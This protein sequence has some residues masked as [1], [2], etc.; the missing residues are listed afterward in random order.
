MEGKVL[1]ANNFHAQ[2][3][4]TGTY[5][6]DIPELDHYSWT[7]GK[8]IRRQARTATMEIRYQVLSSCLPLGYPKAEPSIPLCLVE[9][10]ETTEQLPE[11]ENQLFGAYGQLT[12]LKTRNKLT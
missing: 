10:R 6:L 2:F 12:K 1:K 5:E 11:G 9:A 3:E 8:R 7:S 4:S